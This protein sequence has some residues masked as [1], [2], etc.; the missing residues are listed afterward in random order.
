[1]AIVRAKIELQDDKRNIIAYLFDNGENVIEIDE[2]EYRGKV[3]IKKENYS[4]YITID[5]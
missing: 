2:Q 5:L 1:M 4:F 3:Q